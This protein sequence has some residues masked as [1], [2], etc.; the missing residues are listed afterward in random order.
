M[1]IYNEIVE[2]LENISNIESGNKLNV[3]EIKTILDNKDSIISLLK[4]IEALSYQY[5]MDGGKI[6]GYKLVKSF[7][8]FQWTSEAENELFKIL[9]DD[10]YDKKMITIA[11][12][13]KKLGGE[14]VNK[15]IS[16]TSKLIMVAEEDN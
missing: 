9:K 1:Q 2:R 10:L 5:L 8:R 11:K 4:E 14:T 15:F 6:D 16:R 7:S 12:A 13:K 3:D